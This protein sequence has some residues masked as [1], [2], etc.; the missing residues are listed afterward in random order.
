MAAENGGECFWCRVF[1]R[2]QIQMKNRIGV[3]F[4]FKFVD[5]QSLE[6]FPLSL[7]VGFQGGNEQTFAKP[8]RTA[9]K[10]IGAS[11]YK[12]LNHAGL[13]QMQITVTSKFLETLYA[14]RIFHVLSRFLL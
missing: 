5:G 1:C 4:A 11:F 14:N 13:V 8:A 9:E 3:P 6:Q 12:T 10:K 2:I 7:E